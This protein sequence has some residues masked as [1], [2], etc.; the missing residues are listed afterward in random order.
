MRSIRFLAAAAMAACAGVSASAG[1]PHVP[2]PD[3]PHPRWART[4][5]EALAEGRAR[6]CVVF[7]TFHLD[8]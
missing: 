3:A 2:A 6:G 4:Y 8:G 7:A 1:E 5:A